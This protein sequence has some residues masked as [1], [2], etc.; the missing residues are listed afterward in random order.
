[1]GLPSRSFA[2]DAHDCIMVRIRME[3]TEY[4]CVARPSCP[5]RAPLGS[6]S[7]HRQARSDVGVASRKP[8]LSVHR[9]AACS[10]VKA[11]RN[12]SCVKA[13]RRQAPLAFRSLDAFRALREPDRRRQDEERPFPL[14][15][16]NWP[17]TQIQQQSG[18]AAQATRKAAL[19][20]MQDKHCAWL[21]SLLDNSNDR[22][23]PT[24]CRPAPRSIAKNCGRST[25]PRLSTRLIDR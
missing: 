24:S 15:T 20:A 6:S 22:D 18:S 19:I 23:W 13:A 7:R 16:K 9:P 14:R 21:D 5:W 12:T 17:Q 10:G 11:L 3:S 4:K 25:H 1:M 8:R 2:A